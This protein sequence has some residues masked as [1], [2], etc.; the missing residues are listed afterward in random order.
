MLRPS[1]AERLSDIVDS[2]GG[3]ALFD[4][5]LANARECVDIFSPSDDAGD[6]IGTSRLG[7]LPDLPVDVPWPAGTDREGRPWGYA[8]FVAQI[9]FSEVPPTAD[10][11]LPG[12][13][14]TRKRSSPRS[15]TN[16]H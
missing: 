8:G 3:S 10:L 2:A 14:G 12:V 16:P 11:S 7:G 9:D 6:G 15:K 4:L 13:G 5:F 1:F